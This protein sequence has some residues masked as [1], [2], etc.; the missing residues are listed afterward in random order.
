MQYLPETIVYYFPPSG[1]ARIAHSCAVVVCTCTSIYA[2]NY[3]S[4]VLWWIGWIGWIACSTYLL[5]CLFFASVCFENKIENSNSGTVRRKKRHSHPPSD[6][7][8]HHRG[9][10]GSIPGNFHIDRSEAIRRQRS[11]IG[12]DPE[13][14]S[15]KS[16]ST[17]RRDP[18]SC[19]HHKSELPPQFFL[20]KKSNFRVSK[21]ICGCFLFLP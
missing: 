3:H 21:V 11:R 12:R 20:P 10:N 17:R 2:W 19:H 7:Y 18:P 13:T 1:Q 9:S 4:S 5:D 8:R 6:P 15:R 16:P 14:E